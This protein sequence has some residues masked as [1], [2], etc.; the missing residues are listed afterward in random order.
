[1]TY[2]KFFSNIPFINYIGFSISGQ[3]GGRG[4]GQLVS[5]LRS[6]FTSMDNNKSS[7]KQDCC[8]LLDKL[9]AKSFE[10]CVLLFSLVLACAFTSLS[11][12]VTILLKII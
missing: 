3:S 9:I 4:G 11:I 10:Y 7:L 1:M 2:D 5:V 6:V 8:L 12:K